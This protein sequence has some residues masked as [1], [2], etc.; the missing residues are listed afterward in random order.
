MD[1]YNPY[2]M[3]PSLTR[4]LGTISF[5]ARA[6]TTNYL[7]G[8]TNTSIS[9]YATTDSRDKPDA[10]WTKIHTFTGI[11]NGFYRPF[12]YSYP[13]VPNNFKAVRLMV[14]GVVDIPPL[15]PSPQRVCIDELAVTEAIY[16][17]FDITS[18][19]LMTVDGETKQPIEGEDIGF[20]AQL[21][22]VL[23]EPT[24]IRVFVTYVLGT[25]TW[26]VMNAPIAITNELAQV[27]VNNRIYRTTG[28]YL[29]NGVPEQ[30]KYNVVQ[31]IVWATY[32]GNGPHTVYQTPFTADHFTTPSWYFP[33]DLNKVGHLATNANKSSWSPYYIVYDVPP[34]SVWINELNLNELASVVPQVFRNPYIE[35]AQPAWMDLVGWQVEIL[36]TDFKTRLTIGITNKS[37]RAILPADASGYGLYV[38]GPPDSEAAIPIWPSTTTYPA[39]STTTTVHQ[40]V[41]QIKGDP[42]SGFNLYPGGYRLKRPMGMY[43]HAIAYDWKRETTGSGDLFAQNEPPP[44]TPFK[45]VGREYYNG[46]LSFTG[47]IVSVSGQYVRTDSTNTWAPGLDNFNWTP[48]RKNVGQIFPPSPPPGGS[49]VLITSTLVSPDGLMHGWQNNTRQ[50]TLLFKM[51][52]GQGTNFVFVADPWFRFYG[53]TSNSV[54]ILSLAEQTAITNYV[55]GLNNIQKD[56]TLV[57]SLKLAPNVINLIT[58]PDMLAWLTNFVDRALAPSYFGETP[59]SFTEQYWLNMDPTQTNNLIFRSQGSPVLGDFGLWLTLQMATIDGSG[60]TNKVTL[61]RG[62][63][64]IS[65]WA[66]DTEPPAWRPFGQYWISTRSFDD[67][68]LSRTWINAYT[69]DAAMFMWRLDWNDRRLSTRELTNSPLPSLP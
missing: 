55:I 43:E 23:M 38:I 11:T 30:E 35:I 59:L 32:E 22:N 56:I 19:K 5:L 13:T 26:G 65:V 39:L 20:E 41:S 69:N 17:R 24:N 64:A 60:V 44:Q 14:D 4:G 52:K 31:Y 66:N 1:I 7:A 10:I 51:K 47:T 46:S 53:I 50:N 57:S 36:K 3:A 54:Q 29:T 67:N 18:V 15:V 28:D 68:F 58:T 25:N 37:G 62:D 6:Y 40:T 2:I 63:S 27:D 34:G 49:N 9:V 48:G 61:L 12:F 21:S 8:K 33:I 42:N 16:P 45:Y